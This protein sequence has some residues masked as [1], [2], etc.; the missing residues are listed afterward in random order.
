MWRVFTYIFIHFC[1]LSFNVCLTFSSNSCYINRVDQ[2]HKYL[3]ITDCHHSNLSYFLTE[4]SVNLT[5]KLFNTISMQRKSNWNKV[6]NIFSFI[7]K[8]IKFFYRISHIK[9]K[10]PTMLCFCHKNLQ[11]SNSTNNFRIILEIVEISVEICWWCIE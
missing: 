8:N 9:P 5:E 7:R 10:K 3:R 1:L 2:N 11:I 6:I 4:G